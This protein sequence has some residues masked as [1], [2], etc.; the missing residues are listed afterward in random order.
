V[1]EQKP[2]EGHVPVD[3]RVLGFDRRTIVPGLVVL[4]MWF[5]WA[6]VVPWVDGQ[7]SFDNPIERGAV[8]DLGEGELTMVPAVG[9][10]REEGVLVDEEVRT[11]VT[12][13]TAGGTGAG[14][15][16]TEADIGFE[17]EVRLFDGTADE[18][19]DELLDTSDALDEIALEDVQDRIAIQNVDGVPGVLAAYS[20]SVE[21]GFIATYVMTVQ[22]A[23][24]CSD[25]PPTELSL[26]IEVSVASG[27]KAEVSDEVANEVVA[28]LSSITYQPADRDEAQS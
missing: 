7:V 12:W 18:L 27:A 4:A 20:S 28:M 26:G 3:E 24:S 9:W 19:L 11:S 6:H 23:G 8:I 5:T 14:A 15:V 22:A 10:N 25:I 17:V 2:P 21:D 1:V 16:L 13:P